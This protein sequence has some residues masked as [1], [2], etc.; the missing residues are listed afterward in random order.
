MKS[1]NVALSLSVLALLST[2]CGKKDDSSSSSS[3]GGSGDPVA[4]NLKSGSYS[5]GVASLFQHP[6]IRRIESL[7]FVPSAHA[8][9]VTDFKFCITQMK[10]DTTASGGAQEVTLGLIDVSDQNAVTSWGEITLP[11]GESIKEISF[12]VHYDPEK[13][14]GAEYSVS[15]NG[16]Q[17]TADLEFKFKFPAGLVVNAGDSITLGL[18]TIAGVFQTASDLGHFDDELIKDYAEQLE[19]DDNDHEEEN[20]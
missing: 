20:D 8:N 4:V 3:K 13:C 15:Y 1:K 6:A 19:E 11:E 7:F 10:V 14:G 2:S 17:L 9:P 12:E 18:S 5:A 16:Q